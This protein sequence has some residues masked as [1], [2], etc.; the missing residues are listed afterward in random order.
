MPASASADIVHYVTCYIS[1]C[2]QIQTSPGLREIFHF[3]GINI[4]EIVCDM[5]S[6]MYVSE[7]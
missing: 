5:L 6:F 4:V 7:A 2:T 3:K 1:G